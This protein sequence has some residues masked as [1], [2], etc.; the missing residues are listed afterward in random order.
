MN[1]NLQTLN[2]AIFSA[3]TWRPGRSPFSLENDFYQLMLNGPQLDEYPELWQEFRRALAENPHL[4]DAELRAFLTRLE[5][6]KEGFW[7]FDPEKWKI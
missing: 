7:W 4:E 5:Y 2:I 6:A 1:P 3:Q